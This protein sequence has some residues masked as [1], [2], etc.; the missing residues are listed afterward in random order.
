MT[1][2]IIGGA[3]SDFPAIPAAINSPVVNSSAESIQSW[4]TNLLLQISQR[5]GAIALF[6]TL[7]TWAMLYLAKDASTPVAITV[8]TA[9]V[10]LCAALLARMLID[11][12]TRARREANGIAIFNLILMVLAVHLMLYTRLDVMRS[13]AAEFFTPTPSVHK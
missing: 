7:G 2:S 10:G 8:A 4:T 12:E 11:R 9:N 3:M 5:L 13:S 1:A 6:S